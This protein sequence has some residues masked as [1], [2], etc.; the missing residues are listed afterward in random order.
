[1]YSY[2]YGFQRAVKGL[3]APAPCSLA[4]HLIENEANGSVLA[5]GF[6]DIERNSLSSKKEQNPL[7]KL[8]ETMFSYT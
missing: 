2:V 3:V 1:V 7:N 6:E 5:L 4:K 8:I